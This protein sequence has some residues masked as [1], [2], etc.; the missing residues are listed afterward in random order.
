MVGVSTNTASMANVCL[1]DDDLLL[2]LDHLTLAEYLVH[3]DATF[4]VEFGSRHPSLPVPPAESPAPPA[5]FE[6]QT[7]SESTGVST[8]PEPLGDISDRCYHQLDL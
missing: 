2:P 1:G 6:Y 8:S 3:P 7:E 4:P 5:D